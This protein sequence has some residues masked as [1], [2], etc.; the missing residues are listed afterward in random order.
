[1]LTRESNNNE[2]MVGI[3][4]IIIQIEQVI[5]KILPVSE[6]GRFSMGPLRKGVDLVPK[7]WILQSYLALK[8]ATAAS[9]QARAF[10]KKINFP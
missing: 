7:T 8:S 9:W 6:K 1:M 10:W 5:K 2:E 3:N 4:I